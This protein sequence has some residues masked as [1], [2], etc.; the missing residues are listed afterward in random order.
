MRLINMRPPRI[1]LVLTMLAAALH[2]AFHHGEPLR[3][4][5]PWTGTLVGIA[6]FSLMMWSWLIFK[7]QHLAVCLPQKTSHLAKAGL[8]RFSRN[9]MYLGMVLMLLGLALI[10]GTLPFYLSAAGYFAI[11]NFL[12]CPYEENKLSLAFG[13]EYERYRHAVRRWL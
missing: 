3:L 10:A 13:R 8:Y 11:L 7:K 5:L 9:P 6:G 12:F 1:A 4:F 2:W